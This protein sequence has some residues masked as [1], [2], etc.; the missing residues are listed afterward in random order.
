M[1]RARLRWR[2][3][4]WLVGPFVN[5]PPETGVWLVSRLGETTY[6]VLRVDKFRLRSGFRLRDD[7]NPDKVFGSDEALERIGLGH[8]WGRFVGTVDYR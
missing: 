7:L 3:A 4:R 1:T 2:I 6:W 8:R 5:I